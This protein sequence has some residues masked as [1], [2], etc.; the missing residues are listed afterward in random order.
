MKEREREF[1]RMKKFI[2]ETIVSSRKFNYL[3]EFYKHKKK[4][5]KLFYSV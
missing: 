4:K 5:L 2:N 3:N 1:K